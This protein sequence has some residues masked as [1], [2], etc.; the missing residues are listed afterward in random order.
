MFA[1]VW[2]TPTD[3]IRQFAV[4]LRGLRHFIAPPYRFAAAALTGTS[5]TLYLRTCR[6]RVSTSLLLLPCPLVISLLGCTAW[7]CTPPDN[8]L[9]LDSGVS[10]S[11]LCY[12]TLSF[13]HLA[14]PSRDH[15][16]ARIVSLK[17]IS[18]HRQRLRRL[19]Q[20][21]SSG[22]NHELSVYDFTTT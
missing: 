4:P 19:V 2:H 20:P 1:H 14:H 13:T 5:N 10:S 18:T 12:N 22:P 8:T 21:S 16:S 7:C 6:P 11:F 15:R 17:S 9:L 3:L